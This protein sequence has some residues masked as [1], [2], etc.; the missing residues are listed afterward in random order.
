MA[1]SKEALLA[2]AAEE[3]ARFGLHGAR[4]RAIVERAGVNER[5]IYHHFGNKEGLYGAVMDTQRLAIAQVW[6]PAIEEAQSMEPLDGM[7][8]ALRAFLDLAAER[9]QMSAL[10]LHEQLSGYFGKLHPDPAQLPAPL[11]DLYER[12]QREGV[13]RADLPFEIAYSTAMGSL[14]AMGA[15]GRTFRKWIT[16]VLE[17]DED[18]MRELVIEQFVTGMTKPPS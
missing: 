15:T 6:L 3:F 16:P 10:F 4:I 1:D 8:V 5:M 9:P 12:G 13:F 7:R 17:I 14:V 2:A 11:R 18:R